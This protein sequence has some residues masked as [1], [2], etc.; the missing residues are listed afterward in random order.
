MP[1]PA[2]RIRRP[3]THRDENDTLTQR[4]GAV[5]RDYLYEVGG[6][7]NP[8]VGL[9]HF[10]RQMQ[11]AATRA[12]DPAY[13]RGK[14]QAVGWDVDLDHTDRLWIEKK[15]TSNASYLL[16]SLHPDMLSVVKSAKLDDPT[17]PVFERRRQLDRS[18][19][20]RIENM[21][22]GVLWTVQEAGFRAGAHYLNDLLHAPALLQADD[23]APPADQKKKR[24]KDWL[25]L[26]L[27]I[28]TAIDEDVGWVATNLSI[29]QMGTSYNTQED[30]RVC[31]PCG[32]AEGDYFPPDEAPLPGEVCEGLSNCRCWQE[33]IVRT[34]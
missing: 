2:A 1:G 27:L 6:A 17:T 5:L 22:G 3:R 21:Y 25:A 16:T 7:P 32:A 29:L 8:A 23:P 34:T 20:A 12:F 31:G 24:D 10:T 18:F 28:G 4:Y 33:L 19:G 9:M 26:L 11:E 13:L 15:L 30:G 14:R